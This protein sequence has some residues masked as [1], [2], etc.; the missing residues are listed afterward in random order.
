MDL[1]FVLSMYV[2]WLH[3]L[4]VWQQILQNEVSQAE[5]EGVDDVWGQ[6]IVLAIAKDG[7]VKRRGLGIPP[8]KEVVEGFKNKKK[9]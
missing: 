6:G 7:K 3:Q 9:K 2:V 4:N 1:T 8:W 5:K